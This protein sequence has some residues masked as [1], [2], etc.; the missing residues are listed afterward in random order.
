M[1]VGLKMINGDVVINESG[2]FEIVNPAQKC[3][4]DFGKM[5][6]TDAEFENNVTT[7]YRYNPD[8]GTQ[9]NNKLL[10]NGLSRLAVHDMV[11]FKLN[12]SISNYIQKQEQRRNLNL[13]EVITNV[14]FDVLFDSTDLRRLLIDI[15][16]STLYETDVTAGQYIQ[17]VG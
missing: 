5:L 13:E 16:Y 2:C 9:L 4:R 6:V 15:K 3:S 1:A 10:Y 7:Y 8:Y 11:V 17:T 14:D 12:E